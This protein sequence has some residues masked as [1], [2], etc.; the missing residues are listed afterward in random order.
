MEVFI[1]NIGPSVTEHELK[2]AIARVLHAPDFSWMQALPI[3]FDVMIHRQ[4]RFGQLRSGILI[5]PTE[6]IGQRLLNR[7]MIP[8]NI[9]ILG[10]YTLKFSRGKFE[11]R[12]EVVEAIIR[13]PYVD[14]QAL[15]ERASIVEEL[16]QRF[17]GF[18]Q[19]QFGWECRD[20]SFSPEW[21]KSCFGYLKFDL[22]KREY[23][24]TYH[25][26][27]ISIR[28][29]QVTWTA[30]GAEEYTSKPC[31]YFH[32]QYPPSFESE[33]S[34]EG[35]SLRKRWSALEDGHVAVAPYTSLALRLVCI[36]PDA[37]EDL[38]WIAGLAHV[39]HDN[40]LP[41]VAR[42]ALFSAALHD[43][44]DDFV[45][46]LDW[47]VAFQV[48]ALVR[49]L[50]MDLTEILNLRQ[51]ICRMANERGVTYTTAFLQQLGVEAKDGVWHQLRAD[52]DPLQKMWLNCTKALESYR[53]AEDTAET[54]DTFMWLHVAVTPT[55]T[56]LDGPLPDKSN[57]V[58][59]QYSEHASNFLRVRFV[60][61]NDN[62]YRLDREV[63]D[64][65]FIHRRFG[66]V[67]L[68]GLD[69]AGR[70]FEFL[71]YSQSGLKQHAVWFMT[72]FT[73][74]IN[75]RQVQVTPEYI[76]NSLGS[77]HGIE[78]DPD[79][80]HCPARYG[81]RISQ[82]FTATEAAVELEVEEIVII[83]DIYDTSGRRS[84]TDGVGTM[85]PEFA[86]YMWKCLQ[87]VSRRHAQNQRIEYP[88]AMQIRCQGS[89][90]ML[91]VDYKLKGRHL[92][93]RRSMIKFEAPHSRHVEIVTA[94]TSPGKF[95]LNRPLVMML[96]DL[97]IKGGYEIL[98]VLQAAVVTH[99]EVA[100]TGLDHAATLLEKYGLGAS[101]KLTSIFLRL[102]KLGVGV[103]DSSLYRTLIDFA[104][105]HILRELKY[106]ARIPVPRGYTLP[107]V[108]DIHRWLNEGQIFACIAPNDGSAPFY[109]EGPVMI[110]RSPTIHPGDIQVVKAIGKPPRGSPF[111][112]ETLA[113][114][115]VFSTKGTVRFSEVSCLTPHPFILYCA[116]RQT[117]FSIVLGWW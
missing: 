105:H 10:A 114:T 22:D 97:K 76:I 109:L 36:G 58:M 96:Q 4:P 3:N 94:F 79:L 92:C 110:F 8:Y 43:Q 91:S 56:Y 69:I 89:K 1:R 108:A 90:G 17:V 81:A 68:N 111:T 75:G 5:V 24:I 73:K 84:F 21:E 55:R 65:D 2:R 107:G 53:A 103:R 9:I 63:D 14:P 117:S 39:K 82:A 19:I 85:S 78:Y 95:Y 29:T 104:I 74:Q 98:K 102:H 35:N 77:F 116:I 115:V 70:H 61:E 13:L 32:L 49:N 88:P 48:D 23:R 6:E 67:L 99:T 41:P 59:R 26:R 71:A 66:D 25:D 40:N 42:C 52:E 100:R 18:Q 20:G 47:D 113:N 87:G 80:V 34:I 62:I 33:T 16:S 93:L 112:R 27:I 51:H 31:C 46:R 57:R 50:R 86:K 7:C 60:D 38:K 45:T 12:A 83:D 15:E 72:P 64:R 106:H 54:T 28:S 30:A 44:F 101:F 11:A 37:V